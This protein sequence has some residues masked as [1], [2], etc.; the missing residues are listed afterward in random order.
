MAVGSDLQLISDILASAMPL[1]VAGTI[2]AGIGL[3]YLFL[4]FR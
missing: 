3:G 4:N 1:L 2:M